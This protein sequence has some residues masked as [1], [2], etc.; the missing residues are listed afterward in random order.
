[1]ETHWLAYQALHRRLEENLRAIVDAPQGT[2]V[3]IITTVPHLDYPPFYD[4]NSPDL[5]EKDIQAYTQKIGRPL[6]NIT[7]SVEEW[8]RS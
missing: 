5:V 1:M 7:T 4:A 2:E 3:Y 6:I 8:S